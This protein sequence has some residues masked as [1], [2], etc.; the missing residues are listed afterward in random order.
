MKE[1]V[2]NFATST[3]SMIR[4]LPI[5]LGLILCAVIGF[6]GIAL[7]SWALDF[8]TE[9]GY[10]DEYGARPLRRNIRRLVEDRLSEEVLKGNILE[11]ETVT[12]DANGK[13]LVFRSQK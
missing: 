1:K 9:S 6:G 2:F 4:S 10:D 7:L 12:V 11:G 3:G 5:V 8:I 13:E